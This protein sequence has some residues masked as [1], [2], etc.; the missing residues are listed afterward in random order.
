MY[1]AA[2]QNKV[3]ATMEVWRS[4]NHVFISVQS[5]TVS[6]CLYK[7]IIKYL[8]ALFVKISL[9]LIKKCTLKKVNPLS[10]I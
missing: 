9:I 6:V 8:E 10:N 1:T 5:T 4:F 7:K 2:L 3:A